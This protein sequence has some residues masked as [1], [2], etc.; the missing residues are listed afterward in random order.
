MGIFW[1]FFAIIHIV[2]ILLLIISLR[3][4]LHY[5]RR[6][7]MQESRFT[8]LFGFVRL[9]YIIFIYAV[10]VLFLAGISTFMAFYLINR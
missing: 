8:M 9:E 7:R 5:T 2:S 4:V 10:A 1:T 3:L 6:Y